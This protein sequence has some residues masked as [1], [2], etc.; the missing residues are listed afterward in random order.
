MNMYRYCLFFVLLLAFFYT[1]AQKKILVRT[2]S[3]V[4]LFGL[5][6]DLDNGADLLARKD[7][8]VI[9]HRQATW[10]DWCAG[11]VRNYV[12][13]RQYDSCAVMG[14]YRKMTK[15]WYSDDWFVDFLLQV[16][17]APNAKINGA[18]TLDKI[19]SFSKKGDSV[20][21]RRNAE[22][23]LAAFNDFYRAVHFDDFLRDNR[24]YYTLAN[25]EVTRNLPGDDF[26]PVMEK[27][28]RQQFN[29]YCLAP[30][31][32]LPT[33]VGFGKTVRKTRTIYNV[34]APFSF[35]KFDSG[36]LDLGFNYPDRIRALTVHE[37]GHSFVNPAVDALP[38]E[39]MV[40][41]EYLYAPIK[42]E[43]AKHSYTSWTQCLYEHFVKA[44]EV[45]ITERL[46]DTARARSM[47][48]D[49]VNSGFIYVPAILK[50]LREYDKNATL[51]YKSAVLAA[52]KKLKQ[53]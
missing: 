21:G 46:G 47:L 40:S 44:G 33:S 32:T 7:T 53:E 9:D 23:F 22:A 45:I 34:F 38:Q 2:N 39:L 41:T 43:M 27:F 37:F 8:V 29:A 13:Y 24:N 50:E 42:E 16:G 31:L 52:M 10:A 4:E 36:A 28:Y 1:D 35:Q 6:M 49:F 18:T 48:S 25:A 3:N 19:K 5:M 26:I 15:E 17:D 20:E 14:I 30:S 51:S 12:Q 11:V